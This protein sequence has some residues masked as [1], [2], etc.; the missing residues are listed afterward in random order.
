MCKKAYYSRK[1]SDY[2]R[3][4]PGYYEYAGNNSRSTLSGMHIICGAMIRKKSM[5]QNTENKQKPLR[6]KSLKT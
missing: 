4:C 6:L 5:I 1:K 3:Q 2:S